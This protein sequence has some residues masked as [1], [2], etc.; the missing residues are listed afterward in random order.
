MTG[1]QPYASGGEFSRPA[2]RASRAISSHNLTAQVR[3]AAAD[4]ETDVCIAKVEGLTMATADAMSA[5]VRVAQAQRQLEQL[6]PEAS[7]RLSFIADAHM[8]SMGDVLQ[9]LRRDLRRR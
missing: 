9:D 2:R 8:L 4:A 3:V 7:G 5:V 6:I 1:I